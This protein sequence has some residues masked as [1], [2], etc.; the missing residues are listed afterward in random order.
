MESN[1]K[2]QSI[3]MS[4][5]ISTDA[6]K[7]TLKGSGKVVIKTAMELVGT[8]TELPIT[9]EADFSNI[10]HKLHYLYYQTLISQYNKRPTI[11][12]NVDEEP[13]PMTIKEK[14]SE[15]RLNRIVDI[16]SKV[17]RK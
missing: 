11:Y 10:P 14:K 16:I 6:S 1:V 8:G 5:Y 15:W 17:I 12:S 3:S 2:Y 4:I 13:Y 9:I 7:L